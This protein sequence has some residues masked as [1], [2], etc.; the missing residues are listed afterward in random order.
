MS[1]N[2]K[3]GF[4]SVPR[5]DELVVIDLRGAK[6]RIADILA[7]DPTAGPANDQ[8]DAIGVRGNTVFVSLRASGKIAVI[9]VNQRDTDHED[10]TVSCIDLAPPSVFNPANC[11]GCAVHGVAVRP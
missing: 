2:E 10:F 8:P 11:S 5:S 1:T 6:V 4:G 7:L 9:D 3:L